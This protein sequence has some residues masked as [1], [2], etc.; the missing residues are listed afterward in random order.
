VFT[1]DVFVESPFRRLAV[2]DRDISEDV[3]VPFLRFGLGEVEEPTREFSNGAAVGRAQAGAVAAG[4]FD[5]LGKL[6][7]ADIGAFALK[8]KVW[9][10]QLVVFVDNKV[11]FVRRGAAGNG[12]L[13]TNALGRVFVLAD[14]FGP[15]FGADFFL[16]V[17]PALVVVGCNIVDALGFSFPDEF[18]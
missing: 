11:R 17:R 2:A 16:W 5:R 6:S 3:F 18:G 13:E 15:E 1:P 12:D 14:E 7:V 10:L 8:N 4:L 9:V